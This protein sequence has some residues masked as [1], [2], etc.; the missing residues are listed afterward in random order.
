MIL[1][2]LLLDYLANIFCWNKFQLKISF[3]MCHGLFKKWLFSDFDRMFADSETGDPIW[4]IYF[5]S[6]YQSIESND[7]C[8]F[9]IVDADWMTLNRYRFYL[10]TNP[11]TNLHV[12]FAIRSN[13]CISAIISDLERV[14]WSKRRSA[15]N[16]KDRN[17]KQNLFIIRKYHFCVYAF[18]EHWTLFSVHFAWEQMCDWEKIKVKCENNLFK[19]DFSMGF[20]INFKA[21]VEYYFEYGVLW[22]H[23]CIAN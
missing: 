22:C 15:K 10:K 16:W 3:E 4:E 11:N 18:S 19:M 23:V 13:Q 1:F 6:N 21:V 7:K 20:F 9:Y 8:H 12:R 2:C 5:W 14:N 17:V